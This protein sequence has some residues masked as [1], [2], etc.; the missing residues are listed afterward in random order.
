[1]KNPTGTKEWASSSVN[2]VVGCSHDCRYCYAKEMAAR[3]GRRTPETW[4]REVVQWGNV[5]KNY[6]KRRGTVMFPTTHDITPSTV[7]PC[8]VVLESLL[9]AGNRVLVVSKPHLS[10]IKELCAGRLSEW[11]DQILFRFTIGARDDSI[12]RYWEPG[13]P[14]YGERIAALHHAFTTGYETSVSAEPLLDVSDVGGLAKAA[15]HFIT[16]ALWI[17]KLNNVGQRVDCQ[18]PEDFEA[19]AAIEAGQTDESVRAVYEQF[20]DN[21]KVKWKDSYK[22]VLG[23]DAPPEIGMDV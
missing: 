11:K 21:P 9:E 7:D 12:L 23:L 22:K 5:D 3:Y 20:K 17:G 18:T 8:L 16:D 2:C 19:V 15:L 14:I 1:M 13:A 10:V 4:H 6:G